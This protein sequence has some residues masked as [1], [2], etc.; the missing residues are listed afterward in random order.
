MEVVNFTSRPLYAR[1]ITTVQNEQEN[2]GPQGRSGRLASRSLAAIMT[3]RRI[4]NNNNNNNNNQKLQDLQAPECCELYM[5]HSS[6]K[7][8][9]SP[10]AFASNEKF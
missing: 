10:R 1:E 4:N 9:I 2:G 8:P 6:D 3:L 7:E 5:L